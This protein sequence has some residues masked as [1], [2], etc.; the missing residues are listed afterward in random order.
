MCLPRSAAL[1]TATLGITRAGA[2]YV[3]IDPAYPDERVRWMLEDAGVV[4]VVTDPAGVG[5]L[6][7][8]RD[9]LAVVVLGDAEEPDAEPVRAPLRP[10]PADI[11]YVVYTSGSTGRP[12]G[13]LVEHAGL[14]NLVDVASSGVRATRGRPLHPDLQPRIRRGGLGDLAQPVGRC[15][16][17]VVPEYCGRSH[18]LRDWL[19]AEG[20]TVTFL[21]TPV[22]E[23]VHR[24]LL[25][26]RRRPSV[27][28]DRGRCLDAG[29]PGR[30]WGSRVINNYGLSET[31]VV[32]TSGAVAPDGDGSAVD[33]PADRGGCGGDS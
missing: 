29:G 9:S 6:G 13:V 28:V 33:R 30:T 20:I 11:A 2:A 7:A 4:A 16:H 10:Q 5:R 31:S 18:P 15:L 19:V 26:G 22:A 3:A 12:K 32:A 25:A 17:R 21:P 23:G 24:P 27:P 8:L 1:V 14:A